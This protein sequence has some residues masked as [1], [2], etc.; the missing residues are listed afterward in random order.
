LVKTA[1][2]KP[3]AITLLAFD[4]GTRRI[5]VAVGNTLVGAARPLLTIDDE[6]NAA[7]FATIAGL[8]AEWQP[9]ALVVGRPVHADGTEHEMTARAE[10]FARQLEGRFGLPVARVD[11]RYSTEVA[12]ANLAEAGIRGR[13]RRVAKDAAAAQVILQSYL[14]TKTRNGAHDGAA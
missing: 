6:S 1:P 11:E 14:D 2:P 10:R 5:G 12:L 4:F 7:R 13:D 9:A 3:D 8:I